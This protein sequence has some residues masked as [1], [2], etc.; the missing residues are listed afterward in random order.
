M[1]RFLFPMIINLTNF[2]ANRFVF[3]APVEDI[4]SEADDYSVQDNESETGTAES[5]PGSGTATMFSIPIRDSDQSQQQHTWTS[6]IDT[7]PAS[8]SKSSKA[9]CAVD[10][11]LV[12]VPTRWVPG[13]P[14][15]PRPPP[16]PTTRPTETT[17][18]PVK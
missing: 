2:N 1:P 8:G 5:M 13:L 15:S 18:P 14:M 3:L 16:S 17:M 9:G 10:S 6:A 7:F 11:K 12:I 4:Q